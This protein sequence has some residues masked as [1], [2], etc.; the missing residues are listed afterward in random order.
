MKF[1]LFI[2]SMMLCTISCQ[3]TSMQQRLQGEWYYIYND[4]SYAEIL[5]TESIVFPF[6]HHQHNDFETS[7]S[8]Q[9][10]TLFLMGK[11]GY[12]ASSKI[13]FMGSDSF[14]IPGISTA[15]FKKVK[16]EIKHPQKL[17]IY[18]YKK[19][20]LLSDNDQ[21]IVQLL[22]QNIFDKMHAYKN[23]FELNFNYRRSIALYRRQQARL[24]Q[25]KQSS[26]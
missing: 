7:Y 8:L 10:D 16:R 19:N 17:A 26:N 21:D 15:T 12:R 5:I 23:A 4:T 18:Y 24:S 2:S 14:K 25:M 13:Y 20:K 22:E 9:Q 11:D 1:L 3:P 6:H